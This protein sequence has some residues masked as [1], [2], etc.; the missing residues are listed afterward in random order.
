MPRS[1]SRTD[2]WPVFKRI[3]PRLLIY[4]PRLLVAFGLLVLVTLLDL[5]RPFLIGR[6]VD[7][8][9]TGKSWH[10]AAMLLLLFLAAVVGRSLFILGRNFYIQQTGMRVTCDMRVDLFRHLQNL[11]SRFYDSRQTGKIASRIITDAGALHTLV[12]GASVNLIGDVIMIFGVV[13]VLFYADWKLALLTYAVLP[14]FVINYRWHQRRLRTASRSH[15]RNW[16]R[17]LSFLHERIS[18]TR[19][20]RAFAAESAEVETFRRGIEADFRNYTR[21]TWRNSLLNVGAEFLSGLGVFFVLAYGSYLAMRPQGGLTVGELTAF[22]FYLGL[23]YTP[24]VR[25]VESNASILQAAVALERIFALLDT[26]PH[27]PEND[28][29][30]QLPA[31]KG[32]V[33]FSHVSFGY[34][35]G[36]TTLDEL[37]F[38]ASPGQTVALVGPSGSGKTT[39]ITLLARF[40]DP[41]A[42]RILVDGMDIRDYNVQSLRRQVGIVMQDNILFSGTIAEN[43]AYGRPGATEEEIREAARLANAEE[44]ISKLA[45]G[46]NTWLGERGVQLSGGQR[47]RLAIA[48]VILKNP[49]ILILDEA[50]S[51]LDTESERLVQEALERLMEQRTSIVIAHRLTT[52]VNASKILVLK[53]GRIVEQGRHAELLKRGGLYH[54]L[55]AQHAAPSFA[56]GPLA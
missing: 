30:P 54:T 11:S 40:Y 2:I 39:I 38:E 41:S 3:L 24:V 49:R 35:L 20:V 7:D 29:L 52:I 32:E 43:I 23:L 16:D 5:V 28:S 31:L 37:S 8:V 22:L 14:L 45:T 53:D 34:R 47:Q 15:R 18:S 19:L 12:T 51:A 1:R 50:T 44:F 48:R 10:H 33:V 36:H 9:A 55:H 27:I 26:Q 42:G 6:V 56:S 4:W 46:Y 25:I 21:I 13:I 17:V